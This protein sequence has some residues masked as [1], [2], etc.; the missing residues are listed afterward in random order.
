MKF[1]VALVLLAGAVSQLSGS[2]GS[3]DR[4]TQAPVAPQLL[5][6]TGYGDPA[7]RL[8]S[9]QYPLWSDGASKRR[10]VRLPEGSTIDIANIDRWE[11]PVGTRFWKEFEFKG[12][13]V[14]TRFLWKAREGAWV[15][16]SYAWNDAQTAATLA[17]EAGLPNVAEVAPG[18][19][20]SIPSIAECRSCHD[21]ARTEILGFNALQL[22]TDRDPQALHAEPLTPAMVTLRTLVDESLVRPRRTDLV[23]APPRINAATPLARTAL[24]Y[25]SA[26]C[27]NCHNPESSIASVGLSLKH[28]VGGDKP[29]SSAV[30]LGAKAEGLSDAAECAPALATTAGRRGHWVVP[31]NPDESRVINPGR[32]EL[33]SLVQ[34]ARSRRP[35]SQMPPIGTVVQ[36]T[37]AVDLLTNWVQSNPEEWGR[38]IA[39]CAGS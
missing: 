22:S 29:F 37:K 30:A 34:R 10:W 1:A 26:N 20:H 9:P 6:E 16:A 15:F 19:R 39:R 31:S 12:R 35:S 11:F 8:F 25:L 24:G 33:S 4:A 36:D 18:K 5:S 28:A 3:S 21:S 27:G 7:N 38:I 13:K 14:E 2:T 32:P 23:T 17:P